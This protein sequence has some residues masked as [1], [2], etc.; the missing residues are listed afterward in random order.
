MGA[1]AF[2][3][4]KLKIFDKENMCAKY[5]T[6]EPHTI[7]IDCTVDEE[8]PEGRVLFTGLH[9]GAHLWMHKAVY[10]NDNEQGSMFDDCDEK[11]YEEALPSI[12]RCYKTNIENFNDNSGVKTPAAWREHQADYM[13]SAISMPRC[14]FVPLVRETL[15][16]CE[17]P[18]KLIV[19]AGNDEND[20]A[21]EYLSSMVADTYGVS[22]QAAAIKL[23]KFGFV[24]YGTGY[25]EAKRQAKT[26]G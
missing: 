13:A 9:E 20:D 5:I 11:A 12:V 2:N 3:R 19:G 7:V 10:T 21:S 25:A 4:E 17:L 22:K 23:R 26:F 24:K 6:L 18:N 1:T 14:T 8:G 15:K 16:E